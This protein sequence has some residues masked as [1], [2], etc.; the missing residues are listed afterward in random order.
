MYR[1]LRQDGEA[2]EEKLP[3]PI[4]TMGKVSCL[5]SMPRMLSVQ[6][7]AAICLPQSTC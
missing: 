3:Y 4:V 2:S 5:L 7:R 1:A 6:Q